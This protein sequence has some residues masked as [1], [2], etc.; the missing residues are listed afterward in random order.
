M[1]QFKKV[2]E[3]ILEEV[4]LLNKETKRTRRI[5]GLVNIVN[6]VTL[7]VLIWIMIIN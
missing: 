7:M 2:F 1:K 4:R 6:I 3:D 5:I